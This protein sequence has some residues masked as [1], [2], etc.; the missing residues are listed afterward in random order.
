MK[1]NVHCQHCGTATAKVFSASTP[2]GTVPACCPGCVAA[3][4][5]IHQLGL[6]DYYQ[7]RGEALAEIPQQDELTLALFDIDALTQPFLD[8]RQSTEHFT[9]AIDGLHCAACV[10]LIERA[11]LALPEVSAVSLNLSTARLTISGEELQPGKLA[12]RI[13]ELGYTPRLPVRLAEAEANRQ[14]GRQLAGRLL[15][16]GLGSMQAMMYAVALYLGT[17]R[18]FE[19]LWRDFFRIAGLLVATPVVFY[20]GWPFLH[21]AWRAVRAGSVNMDLPISLALLIGWSGSALFTV[22]GGEHVY[23]ESISMLVFF[24]LISRWIEHRQR[25]AVGQQLLN[26]QQRLPLVVRRR[27]DENWQPVAAAA[28]QVGDTLQVRAGEW[29]P[30]DGCIVAGS[31]SIE[32][33]SLSGEPWPFNC[34]AGD[35]VSAGSRLCEGLLEVRA[36]APVSDSRVARIGALVDRALSSRSQSGL[37]FAVLASRFVSVVLLLTLITL[38][39]HWSSGPLQALE[40]AVAVLVVTCP[41]ALALAAPL[42]LSAAVSSALRGGVLVAL[43]AQLLALNRI[44]DVMLDK[45]GT[46]TKARFAIASER[47]LVETVLP[48][49]SNTLGEDIGSS[50]LLHRRLAAALE[51]GASHPLAAAFADDTALA[52]HLSDHR[53]HRDGAEAMALGYHWRLAAAPAALLGDS[54]LQHGNSWLALYRDA[55]AVHLFELTDPPREEALE[56]VQNCRAAGWQVHL[57]SGDQPAAVARLADRLG[58]ADWRA[59]M[60][61]EDKAAWIAA[62]Q[63]QQRRVWMIGDGVNDAPALVSADVATAVA[64]SAA[65]ARDAAGLF[66]LQPGIGALDRL[67]QLARRTQRTLQ[68]NLGWALAYNLLAVPFA[69]AGLVPPWLAAIGMSTSSLLVTWNARRLAQWKF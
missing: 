25:S 43:P 10:W 62:L 14:A 12:R 48:D 68:Q 18:D 16:A 22:T 63:Q 53:L 9:L 46:L 23:F 7:F 54:D 15:V 59:A 40:Y 13:A 69:M 29:L 32:Q 35:A 41:C 38:A 58:I 64:D 2:Q 45:T 21:S 34:Q 30:V 11:L 8:K 3:I 6:G 47:L 31:G 51:R 57:A 49:E 42:T 4:E 5:T 66:L 26:L 44:T 33:S 67:R 61:P 1:Q 19:P 39:W 55:Q 50:P 60:R 27:H 52:S 17:F 65:L 20:S 24:L 28:V 56:A 37:Q 36:E